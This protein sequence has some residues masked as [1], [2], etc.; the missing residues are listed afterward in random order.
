MSMRKSVS[1]LRVRRR[2]RQN[3]SAST[4][5]TKLTSLPPIA[6]ATIRVVDV[7]AGGDEDDALVVV[8]VTRADDVVGVESPN[9]GV[10]PAAF[11]DVVWPDEVGVEVA[12]RGLVVVGSV[13]E[14]EEGVVGGEL[15][16]PFEARDEMNHFF[17]LKMRGFGE[18]GKV[19]LTS[20][21]N[22]ER[23]RNSISTRA[24]T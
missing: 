1:L 7:C 20:S 19:G 10:A 21:L 9:H 4:K 12:G 23:C 6:P 13:I 8:D 17:E 22:G 2:L 18:E 5:T 15:R 24:I 11:V 3:Q 14:L 16:Q